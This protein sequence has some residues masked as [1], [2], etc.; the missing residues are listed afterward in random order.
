MVDGK[1]AEIVG[2]DVDQT[3]DDIDILNKKKFFTNI[4]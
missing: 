2:Q 4:H 3:L 1:V